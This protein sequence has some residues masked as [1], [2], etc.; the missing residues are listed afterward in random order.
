MNAP[1]IAHRNLNPSSP[2]SADEDAL[3]HRH[4]AAFDCC[5][6]EIVV[7]RERFRIMKVR[8]TNALLEAID[9]ATFAEDERLPYWA[10]LWTSSLELA[11]W[12]LED[13]NLKNTRV[14]ELGCGL[15]L[16]GIAAAKAGARVTFSD[17]ENSALDFSRCNARRN[18]PS[19]VYDQQLDFL[20]LDWRT[21]PPLEP[22]DVI[23]GADIVY[24]RR[25]FF[26][27]VKVL[28]T[29]LRP[30]G[31]AVFTEPG[32]SIGTQFLSL[33]RD[34]GFVLET[35]MRSVAMNGTTSDILRAEIRLPPSLH[36][37]V[38]R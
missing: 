30:E 14:L 18:L 33:L 3:S 5:E 23:I 31:I 8:N 36:H 19:D 26:P 15:G 16:G 22:F 37:P 2:N 9:P 28:T 27:L 35:T 32:R 38:N 12:C 29:L 25:N 6:Q 24:E 34:E 10:D 1:A 21:L 11:R 4:A 7:G 17:Y 13:G 20:Q